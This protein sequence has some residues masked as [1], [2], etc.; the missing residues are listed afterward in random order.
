MSEK[1]KKMNKSRRN[2]REKTYD[3]VTS[4]PEPTN[5]KN[6]YFPEWVDDEINLMSSSA[7]SHIGKHKEKLEKT[8]K[9]EKNEDFWRRF[10][11]PQVLFL[12][13]C[14][15]DLEQA[16]KR[17]PDIFPDYQ[18]VIYTDEYDYSDLLSGSA[19]LVNSSF[20]R[21][22]ISSIHNLEYL[23]HTTNFAQEATTPKYIANTSGHW[24][25]WHHVYGGS[26]VGAGTVHS[27]QVNSIGK[28]FVRLF[29]M[30]AWRKVVID[31][32]LPV[33]ATGHVLLPS[34]RIPKK[35]I[36]NTLIAGSSFS[37]AKEKQLTHKTE[38]EVLKPTVVLWPFL[39]SKALLKVAN[40]TMKKDE[41]LLDFN[42]VHCLTGWV[43]QKL[44]L[45]GLPS[46]DV[47]EICKTHTKLYSWTE[48]E[49][50]KQPSS[51]VKEK[52]DKKKASKVLVPTSETTE[53][54]HY[55]MALCKDM[56]SLKQSAV[57]G[58]SPCWGHEIVID[59]CRDIP[60]ERPAPDPEYPLW[61]KFRWMEWAKSKGLIT[62]PVPMDTTRYLRCVSSFRKFTK[63]IVYKESSPD[64]KVSTQFPLRKS[65]AV[66]QKQPHEERHGEDRAVTELHRPDKFRENNFFTEPDAKNL[67]IRFDDLCSQLISINV[68]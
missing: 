28:Y 41:E 55:L 37:E 2:T 66:L 35:P 29:W 60:L 31:D 14:L 19:H 11:D 67:W 23:A 53:T 56:R 54:S 58:V 3:W 10:E 48:P 4:I 25:P 62:D 24:K 64:D 49:V 18:F 57:N 47:W 16:W 46:E 1:T 30:G 21:S 22:F 33:D 43:L 59:E 7:L 17:P 34:L 45:E 12:P 6:I 39:L 68:F 52:K 5:P 32:Y 65:L 26:K 40:L 27:P 20:M 36:S 38:K 9:N 15:Q 50:T 44:E 63:H 61:K 8:D 42:I 13:F 51:L